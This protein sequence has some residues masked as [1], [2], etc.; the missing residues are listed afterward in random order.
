MNPDKKLLKVTRKSQQK[1]RV[2]GSGEPNSE[3]FSTIE[4]YKTLRTNLQFTFKNQ[5]GNVISI[6]S[7]LPHSGKSTIVA[8]IAVA[9]AQA[10]YK[11]LI[12][13]ADLRK[14]RIC[15]FFD[16]PLSPGLSNYI[17]GLTDFDNVVRSTK[18][19][20]LK[21]ITSGQIPPNPAEILN[22]VKMEKLILK[23]REDYDV[24]FIDTPPVNLV[25]DAVVVTKYADGSILVV[26]H[27]VTT[28]NE[29]AY[30]IK[31]FELVNAKV[32]GVIL[33]AVDYQKSHGKSYRYYSKSAYY[34]GGYYSQYS[35][36][37]SEPDAKINN[38]IIDKD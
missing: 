1:R 2:R 16:L 25:T 31:S 17:A 14:P 13:D 4:A 11:V 29:L 20:N 38:T 28:H 3:L 15:K 30:A 36:A 33:N 37:Y 24:I 6:T 22:S 35:S 27:Y 34:R 12:I 8:N 19:D 10:G 7:A 5:K 23:A 26:R 32:L 9:F 18:F 21:V